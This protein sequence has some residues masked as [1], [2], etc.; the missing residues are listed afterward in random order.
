M[1]RLLLT[2]TVSLSCG[3]MTHER[4]ISEHHDEM[5]PI[6]RPSTPRLEILG[7][8]S[9]LAV[10]HSREGSSQIKIYEEQHEMASAIE[11]LEVK[12]EP[13]KPATPSIESSSSVDSVSRSHHRRWLLISN[14][15]TGIG[16]SIVTAAVA[17]AIALTKCPTPPTGTP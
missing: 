15:L 6:R 10:I 9:T 11:R 8:P 17:L 14:G 3:G 2:L 5:P 1:K 13:S 16:A 7:L 12:T 4:N